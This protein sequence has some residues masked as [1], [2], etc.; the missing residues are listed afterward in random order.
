[1]ITNQWSRYMMVIQKALLRTLYKVTF[2]L[3]EFWTTIVYSQR[4]GMTWYDKELCELMIPTRVSW[5]LTPTP[6]GLLKGDL[7]NELVRA[8]ILLHPHPGCMEHHFCQ[9]IGNGGT[10]LTMLPS[11]IRVTPR[12]D[13]QLGGSCQVRAPNCRRISV[14]YHARAIPTGVQ[15]WRVS[16]TSRQNSCTLA[17]WID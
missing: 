8:E 10:W 1:M 4:M 17:V 5:F 14:W 12:W 7:P 9:A 3:K 16:P 15:V 11:G 6:T 13:L 2:G